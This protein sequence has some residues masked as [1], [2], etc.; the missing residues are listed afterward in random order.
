MST[1]WT[2][3]AIFIASS[4]ALFTLGLLIGARKGV[5][6]GSTRAIHIMLSGIHR[7]C[8]EAPKE[9]QEVIDRIIMR[10]AVVEPHCEDD[11]RVSH[12]TMDG[13]S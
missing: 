12:S 1:N 7:A 11:P 6:V 3:F 4:A 9:D 5:K 13:Q 8:L 10:A 2:M